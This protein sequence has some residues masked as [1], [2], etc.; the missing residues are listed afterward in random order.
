MLNKNYIIKITTSGDPSYDILT[1]FKALSNVVAFC[2]DLYSMD[3]HGVEHGIDIGCE[4]KNYYIKVIIN[5]INMIE[6]YF[7]DLNETVEDLVNK[8]SR[9][10]KFEVE[11]E[12]KEVKEPTEI[13]EYFRE[14]Y[15]INS[16]HDFY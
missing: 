9:Y 6:W 15:Y 11:T 5:E 7:I 4:G 10:G 12:L 16:Y 3:Y 2:G 14:H 13:P 8:F 1:N